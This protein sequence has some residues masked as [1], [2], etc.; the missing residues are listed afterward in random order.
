MHTHT[1]KDNLLGAYSHKYYENFVDVLKYLPIN[2]VI[3]TSRG[4]RFA[5]P[6]LYQ[7][8]IFHYVHVATSPHVLWSIVNTAVK[9]RPCNYEEVIVL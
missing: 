9:G 7:L 4:A 6:L 1:H 2:I 5:R 3:H 8:C